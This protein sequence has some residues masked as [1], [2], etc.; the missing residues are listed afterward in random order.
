MQMAGSDAWLSIAGLCFLSFIFGWLIAKLFSTRKVATLEA[1]LE[2]EM[3][4]SEERVAGLENSFSALSADALRENNQSFLD[5]AGQVLGR[6][7][8]QADSGL[9]ARETAISH[10]VAPLQAALKSTHEQLNSLD[11]NTQKSQGELTGQIKAM[12]SAHGLLHQET[13]NLAHALRRPE[14]RGQWGEITLKRLL[15]L[16]G[17]SEHADFNQ[18]VSIKTDE[19]MLRPDLVINLPKNRQ[20]VVDVKTPVDAYLDA[21]NSQ[22][23][24]VIN[25]K[26]AQHAQQVKSRIRELAQKQYWAQFEQAPDFIVMF[27]PGDQFLAAALEAKPDLLEYALSNKVVLATPSSFVALMRVIAHGWQQSELDAQTKLVRGLASEFDKRLNVFSK[28]LATL[29]QDLNRTVETFNRA[30]GSYERK[31]KPISRKFEKF[32]PEDQRLEAEAIDTP[33]KQPALSSDTSIPKAKK[34]LKPSK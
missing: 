6:Y 9:K 8:N 17:M 21:F 28:H 15:E 33:I 13:R 19:G 30:I 20:V 10:L 11:Q 2:F 12:S 4:S 34:K 23:E 32:N 1:M 18:Q 5:L 16:S 25:T 26:L 3:K 14:V 27:I 31:L 29:G 7:Q 22:D 24:A